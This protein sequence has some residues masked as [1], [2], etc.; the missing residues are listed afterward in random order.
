MFRTIG[1]G[2]GTRCT[3]EAPQ[4]S[5]PLQEVIVL[6]FA[7]N[8]EG[9]SQKCTGVGLNALVH[10][11]S[12]PAYSF[13]KVVVCGRKRGVVPCIEWLMAGEDRTTTL[14]NQFFLVYLKYFSVWG[15]L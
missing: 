3:E 2:V 6:L 1:R 13:S 15:Q 9:R 8:R 12:Q 4:H 5:G 11:I 14:A 10:Y 7:K